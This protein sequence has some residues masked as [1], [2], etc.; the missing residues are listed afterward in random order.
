MGL[1]QEELD[2]VAA[3]YSGGETLHE[4]KYFGAVF[5]E[6]AAVSSSLFLPWNAV[7]QWHLG[8]LLFTPFYLT[9]Q[10]L[11]ALMNMRSRHKGLEPLLLPLETHSATSGSSHQF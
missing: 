4:G 7:W 2:Q 3:E 9:S 11:V 10:V 8:N 6:E 1:G 5:F